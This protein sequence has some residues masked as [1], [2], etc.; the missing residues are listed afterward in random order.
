MTQKLPDADEHPQRAVDELG[1]EG[2]LESPQRPVRQAE[3]IAER[4]VAGGPANDPE[5]GD[6][7]GDPDGVADPDDARRVAEAVA[8]ARRKREEVERRSR[9]G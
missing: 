2:D 6:L 9:R 3:P 1:R 7:P 4:P 5:P 8:R